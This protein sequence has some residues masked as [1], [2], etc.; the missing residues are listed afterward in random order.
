MAVLVLAL[1]AAFFFKQYQDI[2]KSPDVAAKVTSE[3][4]IEKVSQIYFLP[5]GET[6]TVAQIEDKTKLAEQDFFKSAENGDYLLVYTNA[7]MALIYREND[8]KLVN[9]GPV[10]TDQNQVEDVA[11]EQTEN[12]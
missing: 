6:P 7:K 8:N 1:T 2:K 4:V 9:V 5:S 12:P 10:T 11:G 3:R